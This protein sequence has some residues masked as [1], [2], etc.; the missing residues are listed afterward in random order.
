MKNKLLLCST[1]LL[2]LQ[3]YHA[4]DSLQVLPSLRDS[5]VLGSRIP[6]K[7]P[8]F[9]TDFVKISTAPLALFAASA[10]TWGERKHIREIRNRYIP[11]FKVGYDDYLQY[12]P[13]AA[14]Y[15]LK[16]A[17]VK[18]RNNIGRATLSYAASVGIM[19]ILVN[20]IKYTAK[21][22]R[23]DGSANNSFP[24]GHTANAFNNASFL[25][26]EYGVVNPLYS[27]GA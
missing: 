17:G 5:I 3:F 26:K 27:I 15:G 4:Q 20:S 24:S 21:V 16:I 19:A 11:N 14:V 1:F 10:A 9:Q 6:E 12:A 2:L 18:G 8:F 23:P 22:E 25:H 7:K 13:A